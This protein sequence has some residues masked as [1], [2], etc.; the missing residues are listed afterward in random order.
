MIKY[1]PDK[2]QSIYSVAERA[3]KL[4]SW[5]GDEV[6]FTFNGIEL[7]TAPTSNPDDIARI[8]SL[9]CEIIRMNAKQYPFG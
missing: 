5:Q 3:T 1:E 8:Y 2:G 9:K 6:Q 4:A 7:I